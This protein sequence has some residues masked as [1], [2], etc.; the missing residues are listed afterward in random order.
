M[1]FLMGGEDMPPPARGVSA[2]GRRGSSEPTETTS[3][4]IKNVQ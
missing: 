2:K 1:L 4:M 3:Y